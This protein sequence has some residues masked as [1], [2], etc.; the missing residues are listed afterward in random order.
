MSSK[1][2]LSSK[3]KSKKKTLKKNANK[4]YY[5]LVKSDYLESKKVKAIFDKRGI[6][7][8]FNEKHPQQQ[9]PDYIY[10]DTMDVY[11]KSLWKYKTILKSTV[12]LSSDNY[13]IS[14]KYN[15]GKNMRK[16]NKKSIAKY[17]LTDHYFNLY[18]IYKKNKLRNKMIDKYIHLFETGKIWIF[19][20]IYSMGGGENIIICKTF[21]D[22]KK[23]INTMLKKKTKL[24]SKLNNKKYDNMGEFVKNKYTVEW[25]LQEYINNP[26][27]IYE[28]KFHLRIHYIYDKS[29]NKNYIYNTCEVFTAKSKYKTYNYLNKDIHD[30]HFTSTDKCYYFPKDFINIIGQHKV[31]SINKQLVEL[32]KGV[33]RCL[34]SKCYPESKNCFHI[35][36]ADVMITDDYTVKLIEINSKPG[37]RRSSNI[38]IF[39]N[40]CDKIVDTHFIPLKKIK[41]SNN[42]IDVTP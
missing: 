6:W 13:R 27:L 18:D 2:K 22:F 41:H 11:D 31:D 37:V 25:V 3:G 7:E 39:E 32:F 5:Y 17:L 4:K 24:Y 19:K 12:D 1:R 28:K 14:N 42:L 35:F 36:G 29:N 40:I 20:P 9:N 16:Y 21:D 33:S 26:L 30:T 15:L 34:T 8:S 38:F 10:V 23:Y